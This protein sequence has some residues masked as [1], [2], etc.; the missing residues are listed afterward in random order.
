MLLYRYDI[1]HPSNSRHSCRAGHEEKQLAYH[2]GVIVTGALSEPLS[3]IWAYASQPL[4]IIVVSRWF[5]MIG[6]SD[7]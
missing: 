7:I 4:S 6:F 3:S 1:V 2:A 5:A